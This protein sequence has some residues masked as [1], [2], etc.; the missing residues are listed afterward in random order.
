MKIRLC[1]TMAV[2]II[3]LLSGAPLDVQ[4]DEPTLLDGVVTKVRD[5]DTI[6]VGKI[7]IRL[8]GLSAPE[9]KEPLGREAKSFMYNLVFGQRVR[10]E[11]NG[12]TT[13]DRYV[14]ICFLEGQDIA[15]AIISEGLSRDCPRFSGGR[16]AELETEQ[17]Q[18]IKLPRY[19]R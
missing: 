11:L 13:H 17:H 14:G 7:P 5:G 10:C 9:L 3:A 8:Q 18:K 4:G 2:L 16:Y 6:E 1:S 15:E 19:C 12:D